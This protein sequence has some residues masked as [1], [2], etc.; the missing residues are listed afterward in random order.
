MQPAEPDVG[1]P[2]SYIDDWYI[3]HVAGKPYKWNWIEKR[4]TNAD[5]QQIIE[6]LYS[7]EDY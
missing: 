4:L 5:R 1:I 2:E 6:D 7:S 3:T